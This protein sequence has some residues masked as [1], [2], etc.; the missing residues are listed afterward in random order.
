[1]KK[2]LIISYYW[3]P[4]GGIGVHRCLKFAKYLRDYGWEPVI[5]TAENP[6]YP[7]IEFVEGEELTIWGVVTRVLHKL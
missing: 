2:V 4:A 6:E 5:F 7:D 1:M 3:P